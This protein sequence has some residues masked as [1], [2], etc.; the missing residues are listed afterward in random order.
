MEHI[1]EQM[2]SETRHL[3]GIE[4]LEPDDG[5]ATASDV[6]NLPSP[7]R[8]DLHDVLAALH[9]RR[10]RR[11]QNAIDDQTVL[12]RGRS[13][14]D[15]ANRGSRQARDIERRSRRT[16][17]ASACFHRGRTRRTSRRDDAFLLRSRGGRLGAG[18]CTGRPK[19][20]AEDC[21]PGDQPEPD[22]P[23]ESSLPPTRTRRR[24][25]LEGRFLEP[26]GALF[27][28]YRRKRQ[29]EG[30]RQGCGVRLLE[31]QVDRR[32]EP[33]TGRRRN[34]A[35]GLGRRRRRKGSRRLGRRRSSLD[36]LQDVVRFNLVDQRWRG[37]SPIQRARI[38]VQSG[39]RDVRV[40]RLEQRHLESGKIH[41]RESLAGTTCSTCSRRVGLSHASP[42]SRHA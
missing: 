33:A 19:R 39:G 17:V 20:D 1:R 28:A 27:Q 41:R 42:T 40:G 3:N 11:G 10:A 21:D 5:L 6:H 35:R 36:D 2:E 30:G 24:S 26:R 13:Q 14:A 18:F 37:E 9:D 7:S 4:L 38:D 12:R 23:G 8:A 29:G 16:L 31:D 22:G 34:R 32:K 25:D 15:R